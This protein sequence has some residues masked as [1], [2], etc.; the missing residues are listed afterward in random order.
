MCIEPE[1]MRMQGDYNS[2]TASLIHIKIEKCT[3]HDY[4]KSEEE[5]DEFFKTDKYMLMLNN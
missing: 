4:C 1:D 5:I 3:D 2:E